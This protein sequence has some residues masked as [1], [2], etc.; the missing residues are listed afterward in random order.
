MLISELKNKEILI[1]GFG[2]EGQD[3]FL[4]LRKHFPS[5]NLGIADRKEFEELPLQIQRMLNADRRVVLSFGAGN[6]KPAHC[7][8]SQS[9]PR[10]LGPSRH[11]QNVR[12][13]QGKRNQIPNRRRLSYLQRKRRR[14]EP[15]CQGVQSE[16]PAV[17]ANFQ[18][19]RGVRRASPARIP[20]GKTLWRAKRKGG[21][22]A[23]T[24][25]TPAASFGARGNV[26]GNHVLQRLP[27]H[28]P[29]SD[30]R[31]LGHS[32]KQSCHAYCGRA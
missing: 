6:A 27:C 22:S 2:R 18:D 26:P 9:V 4:F 7:S 23:E 31:R 17:L 11:V 8:V 30:K 3:T 13:I 21:E 12:G 28:H 16:T 25:Q 19:W 24:L 32:W 20:C 5:K 29:P 14:G 15:Y 1:L 10:T